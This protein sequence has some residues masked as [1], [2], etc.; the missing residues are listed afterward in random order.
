MRGF[1]NTLDLEKGTDALRDHLATAEWL[2]EARL[3][4]AGIGVEPE[5]QRHIARTRES[6]R[7]VLVANAGAGDPREAVEALN[8]VAGEAGLV[9]RLTGPRTAAPVVAAGGVAGALGALMAI[10]FEAIAADTWTRLKACPSATCHWAY[11]DA[12]RNRSSRWCDMQICGNRAKRA[13]MQRRRAE[14]E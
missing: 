2:H 10:V 12:S 11:Y 7:T 8:R 6:I 9:M 3:L 5:Q 4:P 13:A 14:P 1:V